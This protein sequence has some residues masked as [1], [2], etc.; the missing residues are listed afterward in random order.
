MIKKKEREK[1][2]GSQEEEHSIPGE[3]F[4]VRP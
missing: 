3:L 4:V 2:M 1:A